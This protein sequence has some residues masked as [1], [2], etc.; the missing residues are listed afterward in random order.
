MISKVLA[1]AV[2]IA[3]LVAGAPLAAAE[4]RRDCYDPTVPLTVEEN[5][6]SRPIPQDIL[7]RSGFD[8]YAT[9]F[10]AALCA[11]AGGPSADALVSATGKTLWT[12]AVARAQSP[13]P[14]DGLSVTDDRPLYW[15][16]LRFTSLLRQWTPA[17]GLD[18]R[19][20]EALIL[21]FDRAS[22]GQDSL[23]L[24][25]GGG[26]RRIVVS[27]FDPF[28]LD[29]DIRRSNPSG[30]AALALD[31]AIVRTP[32]GPARI[33]TAI[34]PVLWRPFEQGTVE[35]TFLPH[36]RE[37]RARADMFVTVSQGRPGRFDVEGYN[38]R[39]RGGFP[40]NDNISYTGVAPIPAH[41]P[42]VTPAPEFVRSTLPAAE[43]AA[44]PSGRFPV[45]INPSV[46]E[47]PA[48]ATAPVFQPNGP[49]PGS[50]ARAGSGGNYLS[51]EIA[52]RTTLLRDALGA[53]MPGG[54]LHTPVLVF[55]PGNTTEISDPVFEQNRL[56]IIDQ[57][58][59]LVTAAAATLS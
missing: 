17:R 44:A 52:Y 38:G 35:D 22:R 20:R 4:D 51:N 8:R 29:A 6:L 11:V 48:G 41:V 43:M 59:A 27:G 12:A 1:G 36:L 39:W 21:T 34:F 25:T 7:R 14:T 40:D 10:S 49:T 30:A 55:G 31:G 46:T 33:E 28:I 47:I 45:H 5:R 24:P 56:D 19:E 2:V 37:G 18:A 23:R 9:T 53:P 57:T 13:V 3:A 26:M 58:R 42:T 16:R 50:V 54:H 15:A 32:N